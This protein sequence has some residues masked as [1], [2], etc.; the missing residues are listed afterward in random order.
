M[1]DPNSVIGKY[2]L[3]IYALGSGKLAIPLALV[4]LVT[5][6]NGSGSWPPDVN[7][8]FFILANITDLPYILK[9]IKVGTW[10]IRM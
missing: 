3:G 7:V 8:L 1:F 4:L 2:L 10:L 9:Y 6:P 5:L